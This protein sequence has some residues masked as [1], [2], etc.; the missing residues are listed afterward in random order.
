MSLT[1]LSKYLSTR[2]QAM[3]QDSL[4][5][6]WPP[7]RARSRSTWRARCRPVVRSHDASKTASTWLR[8]KKSASLGWEKTHCRE[9]PSVAPY[10]RDACRLLCPRPFSFWPEAQPSQLQMGVMVASKSA[11]VLSKRVG[12]RVSHAEYCND[13][14]SEHIMKLSE[15]RYIKEVRCS[16]RCSIQHEMFQRSTCNA[17]RRS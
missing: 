11:A 13:L 7:Q 3:I 5:A 4:T 1:E 16:R 2:Y 8:T 6:A 12:G 15:L 9:K 14:H 17:A 10:K